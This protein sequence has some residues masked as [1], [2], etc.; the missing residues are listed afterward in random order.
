MYPR[1]DPRR[2]PQLL[3]MHL[4]IYVQR[5]HRIMEL[6]RDLHRRRVH[7]MADAALTHAAACHHHSCYDSGCVFGRCIVGKRFAWRL[8]KEPVLD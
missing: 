7:E 2:H 3:L 5:V 6:S 8:C 1:V 4:R